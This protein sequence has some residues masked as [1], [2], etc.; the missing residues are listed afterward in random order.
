MGSVLHYGSG[1]QEHSREVLETVFMQPK[2]TID[3]IKYVVREANPA[4]VNAELRALDSQIRN[5][6]DLKQHLESGELTRSLLT[7]VWALAKGI[8]DKPKFKRQD[9]TLMLELLKGFKLLR[10]LGAPCDA[11]IERYVVP[12]M[13]PNQTLP[14]EYITPEWWCP[15]KAMNAADM[16]DDSEPPE[17]AVAAMRVAYEVVGGRLPLSF[18][19]E[20]QVSLSLDTSMLLNPEHYAPE[21]S[22]V[23]D[24]V[25]DWVVGSV[26]SQTYKCSGSSVTE[27]VVVSQR[28]KF[29]R[30]STAGE[31]MLRH[32]ARFG[33]H[34]TPNTIEC[35]NTFWGLF[36]QRWRKRRQRRR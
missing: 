10:I 23:L 20:L 34:N 31:D 4:D 2:F 24:S 3:A 15:E 18:M 6:R 36:S 17:T 22:S 28:A 32:V 5:Q 26:L 25:V 8:D 35:F 29:C 27:W 13:L 33:C 19:S 12:A 7:E 30:V 14:V 9:H 21:A 1:T 11:K 16:Q